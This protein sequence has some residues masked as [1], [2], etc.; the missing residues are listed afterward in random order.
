MESAC[1]S[2]TKN[3]LTFPTPGHTLCRSRG[4]VVVT[5]SDLGPEADRPDFPTGRYLATFLSWHRFGQAI[6]QGS[7][8]QKALADLASQCETDEASLRKHC[9]IQEG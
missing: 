9:E 6:G 3:S 1:K 7:S 4:K 2:S 5:I 8:P